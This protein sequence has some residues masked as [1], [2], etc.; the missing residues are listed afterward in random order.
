MYRFFLLAG[1]NYSYH[2][3]EEGE[4]AQLEDARAARL[5]RYILGM[6][7]SVF[8]ATLVVRIT[9]CENIKGISSEVASLKAKVANLRNDVDYLKSTD[10]SFL[11]GRLDDLDK[12]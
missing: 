10:I 5:E 7:D 11:L 6:I 12:F 2:Y 1:K 3:P 8:I 9:T 4:L